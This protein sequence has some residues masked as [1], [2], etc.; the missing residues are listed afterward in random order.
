MPLA[1]QE[2]ALHSLGPALRAESLRQEGPL[3]AQQLRSLLGSPCW[4][5]GHHPLWSVCKTKPE[6]NSQGPALPRGCSGNPGPPQPAGSWYPPHQSQSLLQAKSCTVSQPR[7]HPN[8]VFV[9]SDVR[10]S[11]AV[12]ALAASCTDTYKGREEQA[13]SG[14]GE[15]GEPKSLCL[16]F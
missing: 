12:Q 1:A 5:L 16:G 11:S 9:P 15:T 2:P 8:L 13:D 3:K 6:R 4:D 14:S 10:L 7:Q